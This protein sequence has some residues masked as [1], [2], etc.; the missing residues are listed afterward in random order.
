MMNK[1][2]IFFIFLGLVSCKGKVVQDVQTTFVKKGNFTEELTEEGTVRAVNSISINAPNISYRYGA[3]KITHMAGDG[4]EV[5]K[6]DT[7][8]TFDP[9][10]LKKSIITSQ[11]QLEIANAEFEKLKATQQSEIEDL[12][13][14]LEITQISQKI[15]KINFEQ[16]TYESEVT[17]KE[18]NLKL[19]TANIALAR[20]KEQIEN[21]KKIQKE[22]IFQKS[23]N[24]KQLKASLDDAN[25]S[26]NN[27][28]VISP[29]PGIAILKD[30]WMTNQKWQ[31][32]DQPYSGTTLIELP[33]L[34]VMMAE[35]KINEVDIAKITTGLTVEIKPDAYSD[36]VFSGKVIAIANLAQNKD[37]KSKIKIFPVKLAINSKSVSL[38]PGLTVSCKIKIKE[39]KGV[40]YVPVEA[41]FKEQGNEFVYVKTTSGFKR[42]DIKI[43]AVN[44]DFVVVKSGLEENEELALADPY[45]NKEEGKEKDK[46]QGIKN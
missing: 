33:D 15:S 41:I 20:A 34:S 37:S 7:V 21:R 6:G 46:T 26:L 22:D 42:K 13:S 5:N 18:I 27:L 39:M 10:E 24:I 9:S 35:V 11:Q 25:A 17:K 29:A 40:L 12:E 45:L 44:T 23:L 1:N 38:L 19:E 30:N 28:F 36:T 4:K 2:L 8:I 14:D 32:G 43:G 31:V 16:A 3:L